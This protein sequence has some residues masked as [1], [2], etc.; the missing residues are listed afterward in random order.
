MSYQSSTRPIPSEHSSQLPMTEQV[1][2]GEARARYL[3]GDG[4][5]TIISRP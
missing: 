4:A 5:G 2:A 1:T 3:V